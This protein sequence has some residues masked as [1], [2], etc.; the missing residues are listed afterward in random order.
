MPFWTRRNDVQKAM[1]DFTAPLSSTI[2]W[3]ISLVQ[4]WTPRWPHWVGSSCFWRSMRTF[5]Y[6][7]QA[8]RCA[9]TLQIHS[10][11]MRIW[12]VSWTHVVCSLV[13][14]T[15]GKWLMDRWMNGWVVGDWENER[16]CGWMDGLIW[17]TTAQKMLIMTL[18][19]TFPCA[20]P[21]IC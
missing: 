9:L 15:S 18:C 17:S 10:L 13:F 2:C 19:K 3:L 16:V 7:L 20:F 12:D 21:F 5:R 8:E 4:D 14:R 1:M 6:G 11:A